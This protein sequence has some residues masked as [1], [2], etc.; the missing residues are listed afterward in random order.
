MRKIIANYW[1]GFKDALEIM[2][3]AFISKDYGRHG[4][5]RYA[6]VQPS[7]ARKLVLAPTN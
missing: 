7:Y 4:I 2:G 6:I 3:V 5:S 1:W